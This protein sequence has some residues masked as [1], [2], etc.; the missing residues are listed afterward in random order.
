M[1][2]VKGEMSAWEKVKMTLDLRKQ[3]VAINKYLQ[4]QI[5]EAKQ[6]D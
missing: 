1:K 3:T 4:K 6:K 2:I 5:E